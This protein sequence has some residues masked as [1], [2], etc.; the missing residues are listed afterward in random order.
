MFDLE[1]DIPQQ[2]VRALPGGST[3]SAESQPLTRISLTTSKA[4]S[5]PPQQQQPS[6]GSAAGSNAR[7]VCI[8]PA[9]SS[10]GAA[11]T[12]KS[13]IMPRLTASSAAGKS[14]TDEEEKM[15]SSPQTS[16]DSTSHTLPKD[17]K[18]L[19]MGSSGKEE[20]KGS[21]QGVTFIWLIY[22]Y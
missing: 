7:M 14:Q 15:D 11:A 5:T 21:I 13:V 1:A 8:N 19:E 3:T 9:A 18:S 20:F 12:V 6:S 2:T 4:P 22:L 17:V 10:P 16:P